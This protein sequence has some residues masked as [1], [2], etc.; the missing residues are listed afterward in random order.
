MSKE[1]STWLRNMIKVGFTEIN[2]H[3]WHC[4]KPFNCDN[5]N[6][7]PLAIPVQE[8][9]DDLFNWEV[10][11]RPAGHMKIVN[12][13][14]VW[15]E[16]SRGQFAIVA[17][18]NDQT[19]GYATDHYDPHQYAATLID[20]T[21]KIV[22]DTDLGLSSIG[23]LA[24]RSRAWAQ[25][26]LPATVTSAE[27]VE[28]R[29]RLLVT[30]SHDKT[31]GSQYKMINGIV[32]CDNTLEMALG[33]K[34]TSYRK[35]HSGSDPFKVLDARKVLDLVTQAS[36]DF[37]EEIKK[38]CEIEVGT[39]AL[40]LWLDQLC[41]VKSDSKNALTMATKKRDQMLALWNS[42]PRCAPWA[43]TGFGAIQMIN[44]HR[45]HIQTVRGADRAERNMEKII[46]G[47]FAAEDQKEMDLLFKILAD[48]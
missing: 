24:N 41:E 32:V 45:Q 21:H 29:P 18:D 48:A 4:P 3:P 30:T 22:D 26:E 43:G 19:F 11:M 16:D 1:S 7:Y 44:T 10:E 28:F 39:K 20:F 14:E 31:L 25:F 8:A 27:G 13:Q 23:L 36:E 40:D 12:D 35:K 37:Q 34:G 17:N 47:K 6:H 33:E 15:V 46:S 38:L 5:S 9:K 2:G 42:D